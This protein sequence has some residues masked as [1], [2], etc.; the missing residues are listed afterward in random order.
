MATKLARVVT[1]CW[2]TPLTK[3]RD[4]L[5]TQSPE[6]LVSALRQYLWLPQVVTY[7]GETPANYSHDLLMMWSSDK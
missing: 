1:Y 7:G 5:I 2:K 4:L 3:S 6:N